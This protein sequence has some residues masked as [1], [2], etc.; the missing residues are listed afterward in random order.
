MPD[1]TIAT[2]TFDVASSLAD[3]TTLVNSAWGVIV[4]NPVLSI[5]VGSLLIGV[6]FNIFSRAK[7]A[8]VS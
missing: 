2:A 6:G 8:A 5:C 7:S 1:I 4:A 3:M